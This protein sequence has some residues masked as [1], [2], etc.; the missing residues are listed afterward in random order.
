MTGDRCAWKFQIA[1]LSDLL[2][3][4]CQGMSSIR[5]TR[6]AEG[7]LILLVVSHFRDQVKTLKSAFS[8]TLE[9]VSLDRTVFYKKWV[10][11]VVSRL[12]LCNNPH[13]LH[14]SPEL[15]RS[16]FLRGILLETSEVG[17]GKER[18]IFQ[19]W[20]L[21]SLSQYRCSSY[22]FECTVLNKMFPTHLQGA[23]PIWICFLFAS[24][25]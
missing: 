22:T 21:I 19:V 25:N 18:E 8:G 2:M 15:L 10:N 5:L 9:W 23:K 14:S 3:Y 17:E 12:N 24:N 6:V 4:P 7:Q 13:V 1:S 11:N 16:S 20:A